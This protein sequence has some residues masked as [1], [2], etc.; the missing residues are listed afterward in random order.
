[1]T[2]AC[3]L[4]SPAS[5]QATCRVPGHDEP[6]T[7]VFAEVDHH[8]DRGVSDLLC[9]Q[10]TSHFMHKHPPLLPADTAYSSSEES[11]AAKLD[12]NA[13]CPAAR[14]LLSYTKLPTTH[15]FACKRGHAPSQLVAAVCAHLVAGSSAIMNMIIASLLRGVHGCAQHPFANCVSRYIP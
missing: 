1:M 11:I 8:P 6:G 10:P 15:S 12:I 14:G 4:D 3:L 2:F 13:V 9:K 7:P 5:K